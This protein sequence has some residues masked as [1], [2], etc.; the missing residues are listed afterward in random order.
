MKFNKIKV[1]SKKNKI[2]IVNLWNNEYPRELAYN[3]VS[4]FESYL[5]KLADQAYILL[6]DANDNLGGWYFDF[7]RENEK[8]FAIIIDS[9]LQHKGLG[10]KLLNFAKQKETRLNGWVIDS[11]DSLKKDGTLYKSP[12]NF[13]LKNGFEIL[14]KNRLLLTKI[15]AVQ[16]L[17]TK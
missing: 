9:H 11:D 15:S 2:D 10:T 16:I 3:N 4:E 7:T 17:W 6:F 14:P 1:L 5:K 13:Y 8:W 12:L